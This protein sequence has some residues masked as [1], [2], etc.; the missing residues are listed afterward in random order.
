MNPLYCKVCEGFGETREMICVPSWSGLS[1]SWVQ[2]VEDCD[3]CD[4]TGF[5][6]DNDDEE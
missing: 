6:L 2:S 3:A 5:V 4:G 1:E